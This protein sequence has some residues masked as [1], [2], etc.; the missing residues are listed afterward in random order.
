[1]IQQL[2]CITIKCSPCLST[3]E[4]QKWCFIHTRCWFWSFPSSTRGGATCSAWGTFNSCFSASLTLGAFTLATTAWSTAW[5]GFAGFG[6]KYAT[7]FPWSTLL[8][9]QYATEQDQSIY[10]ISYQK[11]KISVFSMIPR[12]KLSTDENHSRWYTYFVARL[13]AALTSC[14]GN[15]QF[16]KHY[17]AIITRVIKVQGTDTAQS[18]LYWCC[19][20]LFRIRRF[21]RGNSPRAKVTTYSRCQSFWT[22]VLHIGRLVN[23]LPQT[24]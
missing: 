6:S 7:F 21:V 23:C 18:S 10:N 3:V 13:A 20:R 14:C 16:V 12:H 19:T 22:T 1:M 17:G 5:S 11:R 2:R 9:H 8:K 15:Q 4:T 24:T